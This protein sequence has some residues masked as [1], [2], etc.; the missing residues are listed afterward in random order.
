M[1]ACFLSGVSTD[2]ATLSFIASA[3]YLVI[4]ADCFSMLRRAQ[5]EKK[6]LWRSLGNERH[7]FG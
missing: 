3:V 6:E 2:K 1:R 7:L 4:E 5:A